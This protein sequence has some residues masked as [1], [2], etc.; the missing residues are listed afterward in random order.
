MDSGLV[1]WFSLKVREVPGSIPGSRQKTNRNYLI[2]STTTAKT[3][4]PTIIIKL[5]KKFETDKN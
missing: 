3:K 4:Q 1:V 5:T 2:A